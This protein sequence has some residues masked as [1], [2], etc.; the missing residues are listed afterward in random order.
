MNSKRIEQYLDNLRLDERDHALDYLIGITAHNASI[1]SKQYDLK[2]ISDYWD[3]IMDRNA[4]WNKPVGLAIGLPS[5]DRFTMGLAPG[6][7][8]VIGGA[9]S[10]GKTLLACNITA[11]LALAGRR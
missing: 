7:L 2:L 10:H 3:E 4:N 9:T 1:M 6:E 8:I 5:L 11:K